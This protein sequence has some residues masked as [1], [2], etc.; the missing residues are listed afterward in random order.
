MVK[1]NV[2]SGVV[3]NERRRARVVA[4]A[5][6]AGASG[7]SRT[8]FEAESRRRFLG[9]VA[10]VMLFG[11]LA[12]G[13]VWTER[14][15]DHPTVLDSWQ[16][17]YGVFD[18]QSENWLPPMDSL[19]NPEGIRSRGDG[20]IY[21]EPATEAV[22]GDN[23]TLERF[24]SVM[25]AELTDD[26]LTLPDGSTLTETGV[27]CKGEEAVLQ[28]QRWKQG[29][30]TPV[31]VRVSDLAGTVFR[32]DLQSL[33]IVLAPVNAAVPAPPSA[34]DLPEPGLA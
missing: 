11:T 24:L 22:A 9:V 23:A 16:N 2:K 3:T 29:E 8:Q 1:N 21:I 30:S 10:S 19:D 7:G 17:A 18:C 4:H 12:V 34:A 13:F 26:S 20:V 33:A 31:E 6:A 32:D 5:A 28:V 14:Q 15:Y 25:G 27:F